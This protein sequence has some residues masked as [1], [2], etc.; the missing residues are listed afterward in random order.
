MDVLDHCSAESFPNV[1]RLLRAIIITPRVEFVSATEYSQAYSIHVTGPGSPWP[2]KTARVW[3]CSVGHGA[4]RAV[5]LIYTDVNFIK[6]GLAS[7][8]RKHAAVHAACQ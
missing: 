4:D 6:I 8:A 1:H 3:P 5:I 7:A 2:A